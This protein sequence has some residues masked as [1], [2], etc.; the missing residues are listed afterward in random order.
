[1]FTHWRIKK[2]LMIKKKS[3]YSKFN[4]YLRLSLLIIIITVLHGCSFLPK[5]EQVLA[6][7]L[8]EPAQLDLETAEVER[9]ETIKKVRGAG[10]T[11]ASTLH[12][13]KYTTDGERSR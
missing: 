7:P 12:E 10:N 1:M 11:V 6:P 5:E 2:L 8:A 3:L 13:L 9:G 4:V